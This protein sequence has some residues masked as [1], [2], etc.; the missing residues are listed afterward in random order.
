[1]HDLRYWF[2]RPSSGGV[3]GMHYGFDTDG[4]RSRSDCDAYGDF[5]RPTER[6][7]LKKYLKLPGFESFYAPKAKVLGRGPLRIVRTYQGRKIVADLRIDGEDL[8]LYFD[9]ITRMLYSCGPF[10][11][12]ALDLYSMNFYYF[13]IKITPKKQVLL[14]PMSS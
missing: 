11:A 8:T 14:A 1:M 2:Q 12:E 9:P 7:D 3:H 10:R 13:S 6:D 4:R 5:D